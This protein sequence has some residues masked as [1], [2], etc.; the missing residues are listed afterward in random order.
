MPNKSSTKTHC[1]V[2]WLLKSLPGSK[3]LPRPHYPGPTEQ[4]QG[5]LKAPQRWSHAVVLIG[6]RSYEGQS[7]RDNT[8]LYCKG[9][10]DQEVGR[11]G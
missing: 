6:A 9:G 7:E 1:E 11:G 4:G 8:G 5:W 2:Q 10:E 3:D